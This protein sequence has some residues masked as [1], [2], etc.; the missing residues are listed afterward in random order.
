MTVYPVTTA[1]ID[2]YIPYQQLKSSFTD[3]R[4]L[5]S[6]PHR[7]RATPRNSCHV[8]WRT[9]FIHFSTYFETRLQVLSNPNTPIELFKHRFGFRDH[10]Y[11]YLGVISLSLDTLSVISPISV[12]EHFIS[13][14]VPHRLGLYFL[15]SNRLISNIVLNLLT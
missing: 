14:V 1:L 7:L 12:P 2:L 15:Y 11:Q 10:V 4:P 5:Y 13:D 3:S 6:L 8:Y 9:S